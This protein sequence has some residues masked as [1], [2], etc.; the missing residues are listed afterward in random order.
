MWV[1]FLTHILTHTRKG[2]KSAGQE[3][4]AS[5]PAFFLPYITCSM[6]MSGNCYLPCRFT[7]IWTWTG[8]SL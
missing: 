2:L 1:K 6:N 4:C 7:G 8:P 3:V 5:R